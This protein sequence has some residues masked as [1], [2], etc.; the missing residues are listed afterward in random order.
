MKSRYILKLG[1]L[2]DRLYHPIFYFFSLILAFISFSFVMWEPQQFAQNIG[3][4]N[5][6]TGPLIIWST[7]TGF[8]HGLGFKP[9]NWIWRISFF[10]PLAWLFMLWI[11]MNLYV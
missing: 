6:F 4:F 8:I 11:I 5:L 2:Y 1:D 7:C 9:R 10:P 3:G